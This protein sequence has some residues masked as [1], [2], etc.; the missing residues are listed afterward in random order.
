MKRT[1][2]RFVT[3]TGNS[4]NTQYT[5]PDIPELDEKKVKAIQVVTAS[6]LSNTPSGA[7]IINDTD[8]L[9]CGL[10]LIERDSNERILEQMP[11]FNLQRE[12]NSGLLITFD[13]PQK[14]S[15]TQSYV[16]T[17]DATT[18]IAAA[19]VVGFIIYY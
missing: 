8:A 12:K 5:F 6:V 4:A 15:F 1:I 18:G 9:E 19:E 3:F 2:T 16:E 17:F 7:T 14:I 13:T 10:T 11:L